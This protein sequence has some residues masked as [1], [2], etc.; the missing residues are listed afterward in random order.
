MEP[1]NVAQGDWRKLR[2]G[3]GYMR[4]GTRERTMTT[5]QS[6][7]QWN[8]TRTSGKEDVPMY[9][10]CTRGAEIAMCAAMCFAR[11]AFGMSGAWIR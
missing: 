4:R 2:L 1:E 5:Q 10:L 9:P 6:G 11:C 8:G 7:R 3:H